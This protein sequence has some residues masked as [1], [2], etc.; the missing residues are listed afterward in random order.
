MVRVLVGTSGQDAF[1][2]GVINVEEVIDVMP[3]G[4]RYEQW[5]IVLHKFLDRIRHVG[6]TFIAPFIIPS[7]DLVAGPFFG[8]CLNQSAD[9]S[10]DAPLATQSL[11]S[12]A[13]I[14]AK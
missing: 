12:S 8:V 13:D 4:R 14:C 6:K 9:R 10:A 2:L 3:D 5:N 1:F 11:K 7:N